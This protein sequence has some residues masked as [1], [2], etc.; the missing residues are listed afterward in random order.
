MYIFKKG[1]NSGR[2]ENIEEKEL[3]KQFKEKKYRWED[4]REILKKVV[5]TRE[6]KEE[7][8]TE[9]RYR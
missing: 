4:C 9:R 3:D 1:I 7:M 2:I 6:L 5:V 8:K